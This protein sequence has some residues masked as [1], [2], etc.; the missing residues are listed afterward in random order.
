MHRMIATAVLGLALFVYIAP[1]P[2][3]SAP[4]NSPEREAIITGIGAAARAHDFAQAIALGQGWAKRYPDNLDVRRLEPA[5]YLLSGDTTG[6]ARSRSDLA[7]RWARLRGKAPP[8]AHPGFTVDI[9]NAGP[10]FVIADQ[11]YETSGRFGVLYRFTVVSPGPQ[12]NSFFTVESPPSD[13]QI[14]RELGQPTPVFTLDHFTPR[15]HET[16]A[17]LSGPPNYTDLRQRVLAYMANPRPISAS[18]QSG[19]S[20]ENCGF[21]P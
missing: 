14:A 1:Q 2:S 15:S 8:P 12:V 19:L 4:L 10:D 20:T 18:S 21:N 11:C 6:W 16:V 3:L 13:N 17:N 7:Q 9:F 5:M